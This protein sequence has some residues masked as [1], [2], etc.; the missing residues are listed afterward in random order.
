MPLAAESARVTMLDRGEAAL[1]QAVA[2]I[3]KGCQADVLAVP[4][5]VTGYEEI[6]RVVRPSTS[7]PSRSRGPWTT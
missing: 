5:D 1:Q 4:A 7:S 2:E 6:Q 3:R